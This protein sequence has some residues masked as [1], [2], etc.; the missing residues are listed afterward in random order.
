MSV[1]RY[2][3]V[4]MAC[5]AISGTLHAVERVAY[6]DLSD[7]ELRSLVQSWETLDVEERRAV[8]TEINR[9]T[10]PDHEAVR[11]EG[12]RRYGYRVRQP[13]GSVLT[14][15]RRRKIIRYVD[16]D[17]PYGVGFEERVG[18]DAPVPVE[19]VNHQNSSPP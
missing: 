4:L 6:G 9:R 10:R 15:E 13:D 1:L 18:V 5:F 16:P 7:E 8:A 14:V 11:I 3:P 19:R 17:Q 12:E 2:I